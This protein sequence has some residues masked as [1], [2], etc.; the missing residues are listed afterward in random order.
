MT[1]N[2]TTT[3]ALFNTQLIF[4][5]STALIIG[6][7]TGS[8]RSQN[9][10]TLSRLEKISASVPAQLI[11]AD[12]IGNKTPDKFY[13]FGKSVAYVEID[14]KPVANYFVEERK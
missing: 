1:D 10:E 14:G 12:I 7:A 4:Y 5:L 3:Q 2:Q 6:V 13:Q 8:I 11:T 9:K